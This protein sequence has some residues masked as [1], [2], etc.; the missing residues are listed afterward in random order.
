MTKK[1]EYKMFSDVI[2]GGGERS[3]DFT[4]S[5]S[6]MTLNDLGSQGWELVSVTPEVA[7]WRNPMTT[8]L[9]WVFKRPLEK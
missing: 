5:F 7:N 2:P 9:L 4:T 1:W 6:E 8:T 3:Y